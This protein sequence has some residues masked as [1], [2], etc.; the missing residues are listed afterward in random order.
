VPEIAKTK[1]YIKKGFENQIAKKG[2]S[3]IEILS[4]CPTNWNMPP[5]DANKRVEEE[6][7]KVFPLGIF[8][9]RGGK[10]NG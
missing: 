4:A 9:D 10:S 1:K 8:K 5:V 7:T 6:M 3:L 2:F